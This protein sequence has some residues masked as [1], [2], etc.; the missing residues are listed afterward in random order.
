MALGLG[1]ICLLVLEKLDKLDWI[2]LNSRS[3]G[4]NCA[5][6]SVDLEGLPIEMG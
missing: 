3:L 5:G 6:K 2:F 1:W 4:L